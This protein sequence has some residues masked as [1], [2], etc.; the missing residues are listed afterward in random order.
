MLILIMDRK[1][2]WAIHKQKEIGNKHTLVLGQALNLD[3]MQKA[4][5]AE[6]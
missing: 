3:E 2:V 1:S 4:F 6:C 5:L